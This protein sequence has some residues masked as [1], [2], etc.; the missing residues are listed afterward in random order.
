MVVTETFVKRHDSFLNHV[1]KRTPH[2]VDTSIVSTI[3]VVKLKPGCVKYGPKSWVSKLVMAKGH[4]GECGLFRG[5]HV[6]K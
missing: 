4:T 2:A 5:P 3:L 1:K 6:N